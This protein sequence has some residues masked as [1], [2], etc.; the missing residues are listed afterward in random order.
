MTEREESKREVEL[1]QAIEHKAEEIE[2]LVHELTEERKHEEEH[3]KVEIVVHDED[4][5]HNIDLEG[6][7]RDSVNFFIEQLYDKLGRK[8]KNDDRLRCECNGNDVFQH[9]H[10]NIE[11]Y[12]HEF[13]HK[14]LWLFAGG[15]G[16]AGAQ[17]R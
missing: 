17:A 9:A 5:G 7:A 2:E 14:H 8:R 3:Q 12:I 16:G 13:C 15:T 1:E 4:A 6:N 10:L 11:H